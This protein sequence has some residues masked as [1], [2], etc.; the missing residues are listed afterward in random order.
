MSYEWAY[1]WYKMAADQ[2]NHLG[3]YKL[4]LCYKDGIGIERDIDK[5][6]ELLL[7]LSQSDIEHERN[8]ATQLLTELM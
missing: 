3:Q 5:A 1:K 7:P 8:A 6:I 2:G 4:A